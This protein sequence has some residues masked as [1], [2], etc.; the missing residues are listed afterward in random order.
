MKRSNL[1]AALQQMKEQH[2]KGVFFVLAIVS[3]LGAMTFVGMSVDLGMITVTKTRMQSAVD[4][5]A[6]AAAQEI[7]VGI[8]EAGEQG[9]T[10]VQTVQAIAASAARD[11]AEHVCSLNGLYID[12]A[13]DVELGN[14]ILAEDGVSYVETWGAPPY[15]MVKVTIRKTNSDLTKPD[16]KL[17]LI[18][19]PVTGERAQAITADATA[20][21][22]SRDI[23]AVLDY[24]GSMTFDSVYRSATVNRMGTQPITDGLDD[25]W[26]ALAASDV[27]FSDDS[28][29]PK[30]PTDGF[31]AIDSYEGVYISSDS[32]NDVY[33]QLNLEAT[34]PTTSDKTVRFYDWDNY[35]GG[36]LVELG[37]GTYN[38]NNLSGNVDDD[39]NSFKADDGLTV[40]LWDFANEGGWQFGPRTGNVSSMGSFSNDAEW[41]VI[42][43][44][45]SSGSDGQSYVAFPQEGKSGG[46]LK[47]KPSESESEDMW[48][49]YIEY[50]MDDSNLNRG[51]LRKRYGY[52]SL[53]H[54]LVDER[55][56]NDES[57]DLWR[58][59]IYPFHAM[60]EGVTM[61]A[62]FLDNLGY[63][64]QLGLVTYATTSRR[65][66]GIDEEGADYVV[67]L[68]EN[69]LTSEVM[70]VDLIQRQKQSGHY[71]V[72]TGIGYGVEDAREL[73]DE[74]GR[75]GAQKAILLMTDGQSNQYPSDFGTS[76]LP[77]DWNWNEITDFDGD[78]QAD[79]RFDSSYNGGGNN[80]GNWRAALHTFLRAKEAFDAGYIVHTVSIGSGA[81]TGLMGAIANLSGGEYVHI[82]SGATQ[83]EMEE[84]L[85]AAFAI[86]AG[87]VPPARL[88]IEGQ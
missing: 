26:D 3:L 24:S 56:E 32:V 65:E 52:R 36:L 30:F 9:Q 69:H 31:G 64:D 7:V 22:E 48:K 50:V 20:F 44:T 59:P 77:S 75:Y 73:L 16:A 61:L 51:G 14:R 4:A 78:G 68:G 54:Y 25:I 53:M 76:S 84:D 74:Q 5:A 39:I 21:I 82:E 41:V 85:E 86:L 80:D 12:K 43:D 88:V 6:L 28:D 29:T 10:D 40:T 71:N 47:G 62:T 34:G 19:A 72:S 55:Y 57:E 11:M 66:T 27:R 67:D 2:R 8:R 87:Q 13:N 49:D 79:V 45:D 37:P 35:N 33:D 1:K 58:A 17:P 83:Q 81:D 63:G 46:S 38:L 60:K 23:V 18:F 15:N 42:T 70:D